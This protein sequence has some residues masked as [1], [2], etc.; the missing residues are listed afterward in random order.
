MRLNTLLREKTLF[1]KEIDFSFIESV[2]ASIEHRLFL[3]NKKIIHIIGTN[4]KGST[5]RFLA[6]YLFKSGFRVGHYSS[7]HISRVNER[8]WLNGS[9]ATNDELEGAH[10]RLFT[11]LERDTLAKLTYFEYLTLLAL[12]VFRDCDFI[13]FEAGLGG[14]FDATNVV[15]KELTLVTN[16]GFDHKEFLG[17]SIESIARTKLNSISNPSIIGKQ[18]FS[19][20][21]EMAKEYGAKRREVFLKSFGNYPKFLVENLNLAL[22]AVKQL[23][24]DLDIKR[25]N[26]IELFGRFYRY[27]RNIILDVGHNSL[28]AKEISKVLK[29]R[30]VILIFNSMKNKEYRETLKVLK[31]NIKEIHIL[32]SNSL[33]RVDKLKRVLKSLAI[34][35]K[36]FKRDRLS[37]RETYLVYGSFFVVKEF[38]ERY[39]R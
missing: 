18:Q 30:K 33:E 38:L 26:D 8:F 15:K 36:I 21:Y 37:S 25:L 1:Y 19:V 12:V 29:S 6:H 3:K 24:I 20:V 34:S 11:M 35:C 17:N 31:R 23:N 4:G 2:F 13:V 28:S 22:S 7:P 14:E 9:F 10:S 32:Q 16:I 39:E 5:G 27:K